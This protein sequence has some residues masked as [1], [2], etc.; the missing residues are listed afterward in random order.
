MDQVDF[1]KDIDKDEG[2]NQSAFRI[3]PAR[4]GLVP[5]DF[6]GQGAYDGLVE[7]REV[8]LFERFFEVFQ[9]VLPEFVLLLDFFVEEGDVLVVYGTDFVAGELGVVHHLVR[10]LVRTVG[11]VDAGLDMAAEF[12]VVQQHG[13]AKVF[14][15]VYNNFVCIV[16]RDDGQMVCTG[17]GED[18]PVKDASKF[19]CE[20]SKVFVSAIETET[21]VDGLEVHDVE[22]NECRCF[23]GIVF[24]IFFDLIKNPGKPI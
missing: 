4:Q 14:E 22:K 24:R 6:P 1:F 3:L 18:R 20:I 2:R 23:K 13:V 7:D 9:N 12:L 5:A 8:M 21:L 15:F 19:V 17:T 11:Y 10:G 16:E